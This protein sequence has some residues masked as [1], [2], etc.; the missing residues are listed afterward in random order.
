[1]ILVI[2]QPVKQL[3]RTYLGPWP[4]SDGAITFIYKHQLT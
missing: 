4:Q 2:N 1:M 3:A